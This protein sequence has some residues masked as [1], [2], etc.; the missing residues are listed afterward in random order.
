ME[1]G[2][3]LRAKDNI[4]TLIICPQGGGASTIEHVNNFNPLNAMVTNHMATNYKLGNGKVF[5][6]KG[7]IGIM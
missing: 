3:G 5:A 6:Q 4:I 1:G 7:I 2:G